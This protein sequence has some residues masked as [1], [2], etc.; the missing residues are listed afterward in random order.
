MSEWG[1]KPLSE[2]CN[3]VNS[4]I[5]INLIG[6][7]NYISTENMVAEKGGITKATMLP[8]T[9]SVSAYSE[10]DI[11]TSNIRP[12]YKK[13]WFAKKSGGCSNDILVLRANKTT[14][15]KFL[16][17]ALS[18]NNFFNYA[19]TSSKGT[20]MPRGS[21]E[22]I[23]KY[24]IPDLPKG[25]QQKIADILST[26]DDLIE[27]NNHRIELLEQAAQQL[28][29]EWFVRFRFPGYKTAH[30]TKGIPDGWEVVKLSKISDFAYG[31]MPESKHIVNAG[32]PIFSGYRL[33][34]Y[35]DQY[36]YD[37]EMVIVVARGVGGTGDVKLAPTKCYITNLSIIFLLH[38]KNLYKNYIHQMFNITSLRYL[39]TGCAQSQITIDNLKKVKILLPSRSLI[40]KYNSIINPLREQLNNLHAKNQNL[41]K[42][43]D[44]LLPRLMSGK[45]EV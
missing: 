33:V 1:Y 36:M 11:L 2:A 10:N 3:Y 40:Q 44:L 18:D 20:K 42:Q 31:K 12:Y 29:K 39:D 17:Y 9:N 38:E 8:D 15:S 41:I 35:Y 28:Y 37:E 13:I 5:L 4:K 23:M 7:D 21:K 45:L 26:Y 34:G 6:L 32:Y 30:F 24:L 43:R 27:N 16:Y 25:I 22:A 19:T 14:N